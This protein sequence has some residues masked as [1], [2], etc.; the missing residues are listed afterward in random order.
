M[1]TASVVGGGPAGLIAAEVLARAGVAVTVYDRMPSPARK[2]L[3]A[4]HGGLNLTHSED[5]DPFLARYGSS[6]DR[7]A[8]MLEVFG[9]EDLRDWCAGLGEPTFVGSSGR[10]FPRSFRATPL[11]RAW[12]SRLADLGVRIERRSLWMGWAD[13]GLRLTAVDG[14]ETSVAADVT[15]FALGGA[16]WP[17]LGSDGGWVGPFSD[18]GVAVAPL[19]PANVGMRVGWTDVF[20]DRFEGTPLKHVSLTV[21]GRPGPAVQGDAMVT[22]AGIEGGPVYAIGAAVRDALDADGRCIVDVDLRP[23]LTVDQVADRLARRRPKDSASN[24]L[25]RTL[26]LDP[27]AIALLREAGAALPTDPGAMTA[28]VKSVPVLVAATMPIEKAISTA[29]G[30][31]WSEVDEALMLRRLPGTFVAGEMLDWEAPTGGYLLQASFSTGVVAAQGALA[32]L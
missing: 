19:R 3:L 8:P 9:P 11:V 32:R 28:R 14:Q 31:A 23:A 1:S 5:R 12:L 21:Q 25:R 26:G 22:R 20:A 2:F 7:L 18:R 4:G 15:V 27:V 6:A 24:W 30:I 29:G 13:E 17:R 16:S 10:V